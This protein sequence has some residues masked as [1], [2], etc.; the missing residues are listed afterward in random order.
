MAKAYYWNPRVKNRQTGWNLSVFAAPSASWGAGITNRYATNGHDLFADTFAVNDCMYFGMQIN[1]GAKS[2]G[3]KWSGLWFNGSGGGG[4]NLSGTGVTGVWEYY[5]A[6]NGTSNTWS[7]LTVTDNTAGFT[8]ITGGEVS[9]TWT[10][11][12]DWNW[13]SMSSVMGSNGSVAGTGFYVRYRITAVTS[14]TEGGHVTSYVQF[15]TW[16]LHFTGDTAGTDDVSMND[17]YQW[18][19]V[20]G[21]LAPLGIIVPLDSTKTTG[22]RAYRLKCHISP[23]VQ[24]LDADNGGTA[25]TAKAGYFTD[26]T[27]SLLFDNY[28]FFVPCHA[29]CITKL[30]TAETTDEYGLGGIDFNY[31]IIASTRM[32]YQFFGL[33]QMYDCDFQVLKASTTYPPGFAV[34]MYFSSSSDASKYINCKF[35]GLNFV[36]LLS[37]TSG[38]KKHIYFFDCAQPQLGGGGTLNDI[39]TTKGTYLVGFFTSAVDLSITNLVGTGQLSSLFN[40][41]VWRNTVDFIN[42][43]IP[44]ATN[45]GTTTIQWGTN[46]DGKIRIRFLVDFKVR[47]SNGNAISGATVSF[48]PDSTAPVTT[49]E[50]SNNFSVT[51]AA[52]GTI[53]QQTITSQMYRALNSTVATSFT[54][55]N[56]TLDVADATLFPTSGNRILYFPSTGEELQYTGKT[57]NQLTGVSHR[58]GSTNSYAVGVAMYVTN[59]TLTSI[60]DYSPFVITVSK[61]GYETLHLN[62]VVIDGSTYGLSGIKLTAE[63]LAPSGSGRINLDPIIQI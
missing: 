29:S 30:G 48:A 33:I 11:P 10:P 22:N 23:G 16:S 46:A 38:I 42:C 47:D 61:A 3:R 9:V 1:T 28:Y 62:K 5:S 15:G 7:T 27:T 34:S 26:K 24:L 20:S 12:D 6:A 21:P 60:R 4:L 45:S 56:T 52:D 41:P 32:D 37:S 55:G 50:E 49:L 2:D 59:Q 25:L 51:T 17:L 19:E 57:G 18:A 14:P 63:L 36:D 39:T 40:T 44:V 54:A 13:A 35:Y 53:T 31:N 8:N 58:S 43:T